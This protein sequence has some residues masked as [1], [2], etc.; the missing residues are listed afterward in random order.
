MPS[1]NDMID[2]MLSKTQRKTPT[3]VHKGYAI[4]RIRSFYMRKIKF[5]QSSF[6][7]RLTL[8]IDEFP[9]LDDIHPFYADLMNV[10]YDRDHFKLAL[11]Q[12]STARQLIDNISKDYVKMMKYGDSLYRCKQLKRAALG[13]MCTL[14]KKQTSALAYLEQVRQHLSR[15]PN[16]DPSTR[17]ILLTGFPNV[18]KSSFM[19][20]VTRANVDVQPYAFTT[21]SLFV[22]HMDYRHLR[23]QVIDSPGILDHPLEDRNTIEMQ[24]IT[25]LAHLRCAVLFLLDISEDCKYTVE[26]QV[27]LFQSIRPLFANKPLIVGLNKSDLKRLSEC[28]QEHQDLV[29]GLARDSNTILMEMS[30]H[31]QNGVTEVKSKACDMLLEMRVEAKMKSKKVNDVMNKLHVALPANGVNPHRPPVIPASVLAGRTSSST[32]GDNGSSG[33]R[34][35]KDIERENGGPGVF[36]FDTREH[37]KL[38]VEEWKYD[39]IPEIVDGHNISDF[40][41]ADLEAKL[42]ALEKEEDA[43][44]AAMQMEPE[45]SED[46]MTEEQ[47]EAWKNFESGKK[48]AILKHRAGR[49]KNRGVVPRASR[50]A[51]WEDVQAQMEQVGYESGKSVARM[52]SESRTRE[53]LKRGRE[54]A[55]GRM[56]EDS[57]DEGGMD[58]MDERGRRKKRALSRSPSASRSRS[59]S[60]SVSRV[61][62]SVPASAR[63]KVESLRKAPQKAR[64]RDAR[65][66]ES[67]RHVYDPK[68]KHLFTG[69]RGKGTTRSR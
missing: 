14:I 41:F 35:A 51:K 6:H 40:Y 37:Y 28:S 30:T 59:H 46:E 34:L 7:E 12:I 20:A 47:K 54:A 38:A 58:V 53:S 64:N 68:P 17:T 23:W 65:Q 66:G 10:L 26:E 15:L 18:G 21:K 27:S 5:T 42:D 33:K 49:G 9:R 36:S 62:L 22:G 52:R 43:R 69:K 55:A 13:R 60:R 24:S 25:A 29:N 45:S 2:I 48:L 56:D 11:G 8:I 39:P 57:D 3:V 1:A 32:G 61:E 50:H 67:D 31:S 19:N 63:G 4:S 44:L 16:I